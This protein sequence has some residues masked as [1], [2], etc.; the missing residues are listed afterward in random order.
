MMLSTITSF[1]QNYIGS[2]I[3]VNN[4]RNNSIKIG[5]EEMKLSSADHMGVQGE[6]SKE[7]RNEILVT[8][9]VA[10]YITNIQKH[11]TEFTYQQ[12]I[13]RMKN[14]NMVPFAVE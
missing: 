8:N 3:R 1:I 9:K 13:I 14:C 6:N 5:K 2:L 4:V 12:Q 11:F 10:G 7:S